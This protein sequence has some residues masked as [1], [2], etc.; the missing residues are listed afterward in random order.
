M[1]KAAV[2]N[3]PVSSRN[4]CSRVVASRIALTVVVKY[5]NGLLVL[6]SGFCSQMRRHFKL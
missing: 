6:F 4:N 3:L 1:E 5:G 2:P